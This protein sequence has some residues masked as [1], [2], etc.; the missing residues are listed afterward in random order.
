MDVGK[1]HSSTHTASFERS[2]EEE[3]G[4]FSTTVCLFYVCYGCC[5]RTPAQIGDGGA[6]PATFYHSLEYNKEEEVFQYY[7]YEEVWYR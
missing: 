1:G 6:R 2:E 7:G 3:G 4:T 5:L